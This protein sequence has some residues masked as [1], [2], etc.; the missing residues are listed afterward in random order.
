MTRHTIAIALSLIVA[1]P[2]AIGC[3]DKQQA[4]KAQDEADK[5]KAEAAKAQ[6]NADQKKAQMIADFEKTQADYRAT[7]E[8]DLIDIDRDIAELRINAATATGATKAEYDRLLAD[9]TTH[10]DAVRTQMT[11]MS[12]STAA[13]WDATKSSIDK[14]ISDLKTAVHA[15]SDKIK[16]KASA[17][18]TPTPTPPNKR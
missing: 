12:S 5:A 9:V 4:Q 18:I 14:S 15:A 16:A 10:R 11:S 6:A 3:D 7:K 17:A 1:A 2:F 13:T 8:K